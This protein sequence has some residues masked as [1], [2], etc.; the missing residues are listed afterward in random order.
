M[1]CYSGLLPIPDN[2]SE[3]VN[4][5]IT[6]P[7]SLTI[8]D[9]NVKLTVSHQWVGDLKFTLSHGPLSV[10]FYDRPGYPETIYGCEAVNIPGA[11]SD[12]EGTSGAWETS[13]R[14]LSTPAYLTNG[15]YTSGPLSYFDGMDAAG[16]WT[17]NASDHMDGISGLLQSWCLE[18][19]TPDLPSIFKDGFEDR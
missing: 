8:T 12:D 3:G 7:D 5:T 11:W 14:S 10:A 15:R 18:F 16:T 19:N 17:L 4:S 2:T 9:V 13:C 1:A 6:I